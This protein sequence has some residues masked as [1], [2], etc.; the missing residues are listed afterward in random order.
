MRISWNISTAQGFFQLILILP[1]ALL[2]IFMVSACSPSMLSP[3]GSSSG[4]LP[5]PDSAAL[6]RVIRV[7][8]EQA[9]AEY[10][11]GDL[12]ASLASLERAVRINPRVAETWSRMAQV[13]FKKG[14]YDHATQHA[15][16]SNSIVKSNRRLR[17]FNTQLIEKSKQELPH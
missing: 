10:I 5:L 12:A 17:V 8:L 3:V 4:I 13:Y 6:P 1:L 11:Q 15:K 14:E 16:R 9:D 2:L 7:L